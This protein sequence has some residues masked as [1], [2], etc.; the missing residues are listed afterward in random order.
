[1]CKSLILFKNNS[2][3][4]DKLNMSVISKNSNNSLIWVYDIVTQTIVEGSP[5]INKSVCAK[6]LKINRHT[7]ASYLDKDKVLSHKWIFSSIALNSQDL[8]KWIIQPKIWEA[9]IGDLLGDGY[10]SKPSNT[11][12]SRLEF[13]FSAQNLPYLRYLK[14]NV[15][16]DLCT[17]SEP[18]PFPNP[19]TGKK[20][21]QYWFSTLFTIFKWIIPHLV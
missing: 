5:F 1:M 14:F 19:E 13:T 4:N 11:N 18:T 20:I 9:I 2:N 17:S 12:S 3:F 21:T 16:K 15:Y 6:E 7:V 8:E 10:I